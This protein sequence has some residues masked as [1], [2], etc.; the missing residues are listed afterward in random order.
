MKKHYR[1]ENF[2]RI[3]PS[4]LE[5]DW[6]EE[7]GEISGKHS[8]WFSRFSSGQRV[9]ALP[10]PWYQELGAE[11]FKSKR[12]MALML[13]YYYKLPDDLRDYYPVCEYQ[14]DNDAVY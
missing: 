12:D 11:P 5:F 8:D 7:K 1:C 14:Y 9:R 4:I 13:G 3:G 2:T 10:Y 6:D